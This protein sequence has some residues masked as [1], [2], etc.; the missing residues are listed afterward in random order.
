MEEI[1]AS[2]R[3]IISEDA[4]P[5]KP[6]P[7]P[8]ARQANYAPQT[9]AFNG[10]MVSFSAKPLAQ[11]HASQLPSMAPAPPPE[12]LPANDDDEIL[13]LG[14][15][16]AAVT[17]ALPPANLAGPLVARFE[18][19]EYSLP[20]PAANAP[21]PAAPASLAPRVWTGALDSLDLPPAQ[22]T[23]P[24]SDEPAAPT[25]AA[26]DASALDFA[27]IPAE[28]PAVLAESAP[29]VA[30]SLAGSIEPFEAL[31][32]RL[33]AQAIDLQPVT[34]QPALSVVETE[35]VSAAPV[36]APFSAAHSEP[37]AT[38]EPAVAA[39]A[40]TA[41]PARTLEDA[42]ADLLKPM[43]RDWLDANMPRIVE[44]MAREGR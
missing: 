3:R 40:Q 21:T 43:L 35:R 39:T 5:P 38:A 19:G 23:P 36:F 4:A 32:D 15:N 26:L 17:R 30:T 10:P 13:D 28:P 1:L 11:S 2:I 8:L 18:P 7:A 22:Q 44:K 42:V 37:A 16:Y 31:P 6:Q 12:P 14:T 34:A 33:D 20:E 25:V 41:A 24:Q 9:V 27:P 29:M